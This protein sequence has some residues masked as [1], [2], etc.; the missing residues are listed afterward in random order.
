MQPGLALQV[1]R[2]PAGTPLPR[3]LGTETAQ[4]DVADHDPRQDAV[5]LNRLGRPRPGRAV[6]ADPPAA[7]LHAAEP[8]D[9]LRADRPV[10]LGLVAQRDLDT[11]QVLDGRAEPFADAAADAVL[12]VRRQVAA[13]DFLAGVP[14][15]HTLGRRLREQVSRCDVETRPR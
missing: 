1:G 3:P 12:V 7:N 13:D 10:L 11:L 5:V 9:A 15:E 2:Q 14:Q 4:V 8:V 6:A